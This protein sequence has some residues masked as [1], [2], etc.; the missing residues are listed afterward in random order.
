[1][2]AGDRP[3]RAPRAQAGP[4]PLRA[5]PL[6]VLCRELCPSITFVPLRSW[7]GLCRSS[8]CTLGTATALEKVGESPSHIPAGPP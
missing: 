1:M 3:C 6:G 8:L 4:Q 5:A 7:A 2:T